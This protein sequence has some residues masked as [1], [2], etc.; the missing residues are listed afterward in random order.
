MILNMVF[1]CSSVTVSLSSI[2]LQCREQGG[3]LRSKVYTHLSS[4]LPCSR[5]TLL[6]R[7]KKL[8]LTH[9]VSVFLM[10]DLFQVAWV[11][12]V[13]Y[14][15][16]TRFLNLTLTN[17]NP[18]MWRIP[19]TNLRRPSAKLCPSRL[20]VSTKPAKH[21]NKSRLQSK[22]IIYVGGYFG[23]RSLYLL[24]LTCPVG[25]RLVTFGACSWRELLSKNL[26]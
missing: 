12:L 24:V 26:I 19:C 4:F 1:K 15:H 18:L 17:R 25:L 16:V 10:F 11:V 13:L 9:T 8:L 21:M 3:Q 6:K 7:V 20:H 23:K 2:E 14:L 22:F 5:D